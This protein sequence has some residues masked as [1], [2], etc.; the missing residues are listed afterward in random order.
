MLGF[1][2][3]IKATISTAQTTLNK[4]YS[5]IQR[6]THCKCATYKSLQHD[7]SKFDHNLIWKIEP[8][9]LIKNQ[10]IQLFNNSSCGFDLHL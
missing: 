7:W 9:F 8:T 5:K 3:S 6:Q 1:K 4:S 10:L 2:P